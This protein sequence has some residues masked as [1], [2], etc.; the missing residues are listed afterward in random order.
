VQARLKRFVLPLIVAGAV[1]ELVSAC[2][3]GTMRSDPDELLQQA[4]SGLSGTDDFRFTGTTNV[5]VGDY[6]MQK[7]T[8]FVGTVTGHNRLAMKVADDTAAGAGHLA[9][10]GVGTAGQEAVYSKRNDRWVAA[11]SETGAARAS[12]M[13]LPWSPLYKLEQLNETEKTVQSAK[14]GANSR[15][16]VLTVVPD[17]RSATEQERQLLAAQ[18]EQL[19]TN[20][21]LGELQHQ[22]GLS[23]RQAALLRSELEQNVQ[24][25]KRLVDQANDSIQ[26]ASVYRIWIDRISRLPQKMEVETK[27]EY[28]LDG[29]P[30]QET[31]RIDYTFTD[32][33]KQAGGT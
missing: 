31:T 12:G 3:L 24:K 15:L 28:V 21:Q 30:K 16:T 23:E 10:A 6:P 19:D 2:S 1:A 20:K 4:I 7:G 8:T 17:A 5:S 11:D 33:Q 29:Q 18:A 32:F 9:S 14:D 13:L 27:L 26:A 25:A 22:L